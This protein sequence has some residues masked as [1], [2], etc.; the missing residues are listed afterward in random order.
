M[1]KNKNIVE[2]LIY[3][4]KNNIILYK[5]RIYINKEHPLM[6]AILQYIHDNPAASHLRYKK[7][8]GNVY[9]GWYIISLHN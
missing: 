9:L 1:N 3:Q 2:S 8:L 4:L 5:K 7:T 6:K